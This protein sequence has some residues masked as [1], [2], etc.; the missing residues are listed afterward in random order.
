VWTAPRPPAFQDITRWFLIALI[1]VVLID[2]WRTRVGK[3]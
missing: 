2:A 1:L 3:V